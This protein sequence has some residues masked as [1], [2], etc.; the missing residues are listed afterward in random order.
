M[1]DSPQNY[2]EQLSGFE[3]NLNF[4]LYNSHHTDFPSLLRKKPPIRSHNE[5]NI[6]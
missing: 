1:I 3:K 4:S 5:E 6:S 2:L